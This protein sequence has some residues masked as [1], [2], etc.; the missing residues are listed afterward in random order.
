MSKPVSKKNS[1]KKSNTKR[2]LSVTKT[3]VYQGAI[4]PPD[5]MEGYR[6]LD[7][8]FP[9]RILTMAEKEQEHSHTMDKKTHIAVLIQTSVGMLSG[10]IT[11]FSKT[12]CTCH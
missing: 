4:P 12:P 11:I 3:E 10:I 1:P 7:S 6:T 8:S 5:M 2:S 9:N